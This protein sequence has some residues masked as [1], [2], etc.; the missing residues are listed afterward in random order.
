MYSKREKKYSGTSKLLAA[1]YLSKRKKKNSNGG[2]ATEEAYSV[3][4]EQKKILQFYCNPKVDFAC[5]EAIIPARI[6]C[7]PNYEVPDS[8]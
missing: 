5:G 3:E 2:M 6:T 4:E 7:K 1:V 8:P